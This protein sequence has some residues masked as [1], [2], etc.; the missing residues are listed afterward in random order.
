MAGQQMDWS[1]LATSLLSLVT[2]H[3]LS[4]HFKVTAYQM[5]TSILMSDMSLL[6]SVLQGGL[7]KKVLQQ[8]LAEKNEANRVVVFMVL[9]ICKHCDR[10][11]ENDSEHPIYYFL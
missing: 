1:E 10:L 2:S 7:M 6:A 8:D 11:D 3:S 5:V 9:S 4:S